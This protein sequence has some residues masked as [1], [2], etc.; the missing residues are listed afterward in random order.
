MRK[1]VRCSADLSRS[2]R[3]LTTHPRSSYCVSWGS[4]VK[5]PCLHLK[6]H[7]HRPTWGP[8]ESC[9][10][11]SALVGV[12]L[13]FV[14]RRA[15]S[16][17][18]M[19]LPPLLWWFVQ[20]QSS[21]S[22]TRGPPSLCLPTSS[23]S[24]PSLESPCTKIFFHFIGF[25]SFIVLAHVSNKALGARSPFALF[26]GH[27]NNKQLRHMQGPCTVFSTEESVIRDIKTQHPP[28]PGAAAPD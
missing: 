17:S 23:S 1:D 28:N 21:S 27:H 25:D 2:Y 22:N 12:Y 3:A 8:R 13:L 16:T 24:C 9:R 26:A 15:R 4:F 19:R 10:G 5:S 11:M 20:L 7:V 18:S 6:S 14:G